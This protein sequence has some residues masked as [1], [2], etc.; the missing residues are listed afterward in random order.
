MI[1]LLGRKILCNERVNY[2]DG[3]KIVDHLLKHSQQASKESDNFY[4]RW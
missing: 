1:L 4:R 2:I 3:D